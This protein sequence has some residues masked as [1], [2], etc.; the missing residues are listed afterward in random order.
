M[1]DTLGKLNSDQIVSSGPNKY[2]AFRGRSNT[3]IHAKPLSIKGSL[4]SRN[5]IGGLE[6]EDHVNTWHSKRQSLPA[7]EV[8]MRGN[9]YIGRI[10]KVHSDVKMADNLGSI[11]A[12]VM[13]KTNSQYPSYIGLSDD[14]WDFETRD[15]N[16][17]VVTSAQSTDVSMFSQDQLD[18]LTLE[19]KVL[20]GCYVP[21]TK[22]PSN[23]PGN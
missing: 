17:E 16:P 12:K 10:D 18:S 3:V 8:D 6:P 14:K 7:T 4:I 1:Q 11:K 9:K 19:Q 22:M 2:D 21:R 13:H 15:F 23:R 20:I 5:D